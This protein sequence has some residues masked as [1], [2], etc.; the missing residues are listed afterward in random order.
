MTEQT[1]YQS[2]HVQIAQLQNEIKQSKRINEQYKSK[3]ST[4]NKHIIV[5]ESRIDAIKKHAPACVAS[6]HHFPISP[7]FPNQLPLPHSKQH[8][9]IKIIFS[10]SED[11]SLK[12]A[13]YP[14]P[15][16]D[17]QKLQQSFAEFKQNSSFIVQEQTEPDE[18]TITIQ[19]K[20]ISKYIFKLKPFNV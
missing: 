6:L 13:L 2:L 20:T 18:E 17:Q 8:D 5:L 19:G 14:I 9:K 15:R 11:P 4:L 10:Y 1:T 3:L 7:T 12:L 16:H